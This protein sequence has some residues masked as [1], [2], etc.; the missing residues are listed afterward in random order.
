MN[1]RRLA[2][3]V[4]EAQGTPWSEVEEERLR[5][6]LAVI[7]ADIDGATW[8]GFGAALHDLKWVRINNNNEQIDNGFELF[9]RWSS[10]SKG[11]GAGN[12]EY[13]GRADL[14]KRWATFAKEKEGRKVTVASIFAEAKRRGWQFGLQAIRDAATPQESPIAGQNSQLKDNAKVNGYPVALPAQFLNQSPIRWPDTDRWGK[15]KATC[16]NARAALR[17][18][19]LDCRYDV[20]HDR[21]RIGGQ[22]LRE[23]EGNLTDY[24]SQM[25]RVTIEAAYGLDPGAQATRDAAVQECLQHRVDPV[26]A[27]LDSIV[28]TWDGRSRLD[29]WLACYLGA[30]PSALNSKVG[31][32]LLTAAARRVRQPGAKF[33][34]IVVLVSPEGFGKSGA[35]EILAG[36]DSFS[37]QDILTL[38]ERRQQEALQGVWIYEISELQGLGRADIDRVK[39]FASRRTDRCRPAYGHTPEWRPRRCVLVATTNHATFL[40]SQT[41]NRRFWPVECERIDLDALA[42][43]RDQLWAEASV[44]EATGESIRL[45]VELW[46]EAASEQ[47]K[48]LEHDP[49]LDLLAGIKTREHERADGLGMEYRITTL[50]LYTGRLALGADRISDS[51]AKR[52]SH[53]MHR[54]GWEGPLYIWVDGKSARGYKRNLTG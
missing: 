47:E 45:P 13:K 30:A 12:G 33:D 28:P 37:D 52:L 20:F 7:P 51:Q 21:L 46:G 2:Q 35:L 54:L 26:R 53:V 40:R 25:L 27:Y 24:V 5:S 16:R 8:A 39:A 11:E 44:R 9:D 1:E 48:R 18:I 36:E 31:A 4:Q 34:E 49:W 3:R 22:V 29:S 50:E 10:T 38:D 43:D 42:R 32:L 17:H 19:G 41:G 6:A 14:E 15:P 23:W